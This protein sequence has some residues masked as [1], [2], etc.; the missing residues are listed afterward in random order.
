M[1]PRTRPS[2]ADAFELTKLRPGE[3]VTSRRAPAPA[4][5][6]YANP[7][8]VVALPAPS[9]RG[10][11]SVYELLSRSTGGQAEG[12]RLSR[13]E[14]S[15]LLWSGA[16]RRQDGDATHVRVTPRAALEAYVAVSS[17]EGLSLGAYH[18]NP[19][20]HALEQLD[21]HDPRPT[22]EAALFKAGGGVD[23]GAL[24]AAAVAVVFTGVVARMP[25]ARARAV[26]HLAFEAGAAAQTL[27]LAAEVLGLTVMMVG[28]FFDDLLAAAFQL[29]VTQEPPVAV[30]LVG[31]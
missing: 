27:A 29:D 1:P 10:G 22:L 21:G 13:R 8:E 15:Q 5:K 31:R 3:T 28:D 11:T 17:V 6:V 20:E 14:L 25:A 18:Y 7:H 9:L 16:G 2:S 23:A 4:F 24:D 19:K 30:A 12:G 26:R